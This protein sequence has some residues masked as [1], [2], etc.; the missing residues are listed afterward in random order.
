MGQTHR[1]VR[2]APIHTVDTHLKAEPTLARK[3]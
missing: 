3:A 2:Q 1:A